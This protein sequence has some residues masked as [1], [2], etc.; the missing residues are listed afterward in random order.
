MFLGGLQEWDCFPEIIIII[1]VPTFLFSYSIMVL[2]HRVKVYVYGWYTSKLRQAMKSRYLSPKFLSSAKRASLTYEQAPSYQVK[3]RHHAL[4]FKGQTR[5]SNHSK[6]I[7][8][9][10]DTSQCPDE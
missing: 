10:Q 9:S 4:L 8:P 5:I 2:C 7:V 3:H 1:I 6:S